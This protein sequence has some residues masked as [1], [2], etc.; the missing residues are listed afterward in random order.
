MSQFGLIIISDDESIRMACRGWLPPC[1]PVMRQTVNPFTG[2][3]VELQTDVPEAVTEGLDCA[4]LE[5]ACENLG[6]VKPICIDVQLSAAMKFPEVA[7]NFLYGFEEDLGPIPIQRIPKSHEEE[8]VRCL[9][10]Q[11]G[12]FGDAAVREANG[13]SI[14]LLVYSF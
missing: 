3:S 13:H 9:G 14:F 6:N 10:L 5:E 4:G 11:L 12:D 7:E 2:D 8:V 1:D